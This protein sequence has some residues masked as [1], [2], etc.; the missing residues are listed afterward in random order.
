[1]ELPYIQGSMCV[2]VRVRTCVHVLFSKDWGLGA[3]GDGFKSRQPYKQ[4]NTVTLCL[5]SITY[6]STVTFHS[7]LDLMCCYFQ[8]EI[9]ISIALQ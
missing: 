6:L 1:M 8:N 9:K 5:P 2:C 3:V 7:I 4:I